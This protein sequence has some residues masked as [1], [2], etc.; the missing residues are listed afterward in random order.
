[1]AIRR[2]ATSVLWGI[3]ICGFLLVT[4]GV[5]GQTE[6]SDAVVNS[7]PISLP[8]EYG[9]PPVPVLP[10]VISRDESGGITV[11]AV[12][13]TSPLRIDGR[14]DERVYETLIP[15]SDFIQ[16]EPYPDVPATLLGRLARVYGSRE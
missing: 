15:A 6:T 16:L 10:N 7:V 9:G 2:P 4:P 5:A 3:V 11:R 12:R 1:M 14:L 13:V 8:A